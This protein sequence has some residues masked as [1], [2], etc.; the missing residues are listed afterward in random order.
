MSEAMTAPAPE[1]PAD[2]AAPVADT[3]AAPA[4]PAPSEAPAG[5]TMR[6]TMAAVLAKYAPARDG[7]GRFTMKDGA[8]A[9]TEIT[10]QPA[11]VAAETVPEAPSIEPPQSWSA[12]ARAK[13]DALPPDLRTYI[14]QREGEAH[15]AITSAGE[16]AKQFE[17][18][19]S[20]LAPRRQ[21]LAQTYG[22]EAAAIQQLLQLSDY[23]AQ[24]PAGFVQWFAQSR[25]INLPGV[26]QQPGNA[27][28]PV[29][30][31]YQEIQGLKQ[32]IAQR[33]AAETEAQI[34][35][36][37]EAKGPDGQPLRP[38]FDDVRADMGRMINAGLAKGLDD[39][40]AKA[41]RANDAVWAKVQAAEAA[42]KAK[43]EAEAAAK[44]QAE[45]A[46][47]AAEAKRAAGGNVRS[48]GA[49][50]G[51]PGKAATM[52]ETMEAAYRQAMSG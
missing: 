12:E 22:S 44:R 20:V 32:T 2:A 21:A 36:F 43:A 6:D 3:S 33:E 15:K 45:A 8:E 28:D 50:T 18:L 46:K 47:A 23:A 19:D 48:T 1:A 7:S 29:A 27:P 14:A 51:S 42:T 9:P 17:A 52:R 37:A 5:G 13:W 41:I 31:L 16:R 49:V 38:H 25:G 39:A 24:D 40:Y 11:T 35:T 10:D 4:P 34:R 26:Q 30:P